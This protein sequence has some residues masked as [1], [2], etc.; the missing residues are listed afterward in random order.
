MSIN[1]NGTIMNETYT[2]DYPY[3]AIE[4]RS[5]GGYLFLSNAGNGEVVASCYF[6]F[7]ESGCTVTIQGMGKNLVKGF[8]YAGS[9]IMGNIT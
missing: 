8:I 2:I 7:R 9:G 1:N 6:Q 3:A 4:G 5:R